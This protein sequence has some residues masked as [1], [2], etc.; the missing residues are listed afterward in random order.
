MQVNNEERMNI[1]LAGATGFVG[2]AL[3]SKLIDGGHQVTVVT[4]D[5][6]RA[7]MIMGENVPILT[8]KQLESLTDHEF[9]VG[10]N[11]S[12]ATVSN[13]WTK[14]YKSKI[15][16]S[17]VESTRRMAEVL[18][19]SQKS[20]L[21]LLNASGTGVGSGYGDK[22]LSESD[23]ITGSFL[24]D[25]GVVWE[26]A[27]EP[28]FSVSAD[29]SGNRR[30]VFLRFGAILHPQAPLWSKIINPIKLGMG[31]ALG[32][33]EQWFPFVTLHDAIRAIV[34]LLESN[35]TGPFN[36]VAPE[37]SKQK[38]FGAA[39]AKKLNKPFRM[40]VPAF[41]LKIALG[42]MSTL[43]LNG[44][45]SVPKRLHES[46]FSFDHVNTEAALNY[47]LEDANM[48]YNSDSPGN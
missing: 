45:R 8:W 6:K 41:I 9:N 1:L 17:R 25:V 48:F 13:R 12:G 21:S 39:L 28:H 34:F 22:E 35:E 27:V 46:G 31:G 10:I 14:S 23:K 5:A 30:V 11:L 38:E 47:C 3:F 20:S 19:R 40:R 33:G 18:S 29:A 15:I 36:I 2:Q 24:A 42:E 43:A 4:R 7:T 16:N 32:T 26:K 37:I 44:V